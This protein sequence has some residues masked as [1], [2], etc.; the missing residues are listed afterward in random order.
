[1]GSAGQ[2]HQVLDFMLHGPEGRIS[3][4]LTLSYSE[5]QPWQVG[6]AF[7]AADSAD[8][9][10]AVWVIARD[11][12]VGGLQKRTGQGDVRV[13][14]AGSRIAIEFHDGHDHALITVARDAL[15]RFLDSCYAVVPPGEESRRMDWQE[16][17][18]AL[19]A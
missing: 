1:M 3:S 19:L 6:V 16:E 4:R 7:G 13:G 2:V 15:A 12:L 9:R 14:P 8:N 5:R 17:L 10:S 11:L 18:A